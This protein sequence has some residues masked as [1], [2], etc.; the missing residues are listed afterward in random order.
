MFCNLVSGDFPEQREANLS[1]DN[2]RQAKR[3]AKSERAKR[4]REENPEL[5]A[6]YKAKQKVRDERKKQKREKGLEATTPSQEFYSFFPPQNLEEEN[7]PIKSLEELNREW[8]K[9]QLDDL[10]DSPKPKLYPSW[11]DLL[12]DEEK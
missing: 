5:L 1:T 8:L 4:K 11:D 9:N 3:K 12:S 7:L 6:Q 2:A 10:S